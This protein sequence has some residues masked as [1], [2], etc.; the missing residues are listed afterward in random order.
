M[1]SAV[2][3][4]EREGD[5]KVPPWVPLC[6]W[7]VTFITYST[8]E[9]YCIRTPCLQGSRIL[10]GDPRWFVVGC[11]FGPLDASVVHRIMTT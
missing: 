11:N 3:V 6:L 7:A 1:F 9:H 2:R 5:W 10:A 4:L 8:L